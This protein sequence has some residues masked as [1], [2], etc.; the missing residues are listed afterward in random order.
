MKSDFPCL[1]KGKL[2]TYDLWLVLILLLH[3]EHRKAVKQHEFGVNTFYKMVI[4]KS[5]YSSGLK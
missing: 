3:S 2:F 1:G 5:K 4:L